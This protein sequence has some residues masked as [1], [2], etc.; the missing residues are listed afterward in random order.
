MSSERPLA[1]LLQ[2]L[3]DT[4]KTG[5]LYVSIVETSEDLVRIYFRN[6]DIYYIRY[7]TAI[8]ND[9]LDILEYYNL[10]GATYFDGVEAPKG[11]VSNI[12]KTQA[13]ISMIRGLNKKVKVQ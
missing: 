12:P 9:C 2:E 7:G 3:H 5:A 11:A 13:V 1:D 10:W 8:G 4:K 6:G